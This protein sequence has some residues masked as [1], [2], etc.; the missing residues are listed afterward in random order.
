[1]NEKPGDCVKFKYGNT[2][3]FLRHPTTRGNDGRDRPVSNGDVLTVVAVRRFEDDDME[4][5]LVM[6]PVGLGWIYTDNL[7]PIKGPTMYE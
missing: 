7:V 4:D 5:V 2:R 1:M 6:S 3:Y